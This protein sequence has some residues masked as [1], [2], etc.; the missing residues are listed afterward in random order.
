MALTIS[1][2]LSIT[3]TSIDLIIL[4][5]FFLSSVM[6]VLSF[7]PNMKCQVSPAVTTPFINSV[8]VNLSMKADLINEGSSTDS[9]FPACWLLIVTG[10]V[11]C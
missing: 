1:L 3:D 4:V 2:N 10:T 6:A 11:S 8:L 9:S 5:Q 7:G